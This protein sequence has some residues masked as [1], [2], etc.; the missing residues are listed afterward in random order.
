M[1][2]VF[3]SLNYN[4]PKELFFSIR[5]SRGIG[6]AVRRDEQG[7]ENGNELQCL[8]ARSLLLIRGHMSNV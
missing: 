2:L 3:H 1:F 7:R 8:S 6:W 4:M 5:S